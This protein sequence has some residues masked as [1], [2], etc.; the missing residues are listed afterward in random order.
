[1]IPIFASA[2]MRSRDEL[3][4]WLLYIKKNTNEHM[5]MLRVGMNVIADAF[6]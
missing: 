2:F 5:Y 4:T 3:L 6:C 1:M